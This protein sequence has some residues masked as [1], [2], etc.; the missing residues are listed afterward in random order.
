MELV[1]RTT[2]DRYMNKIVLRKW[3][4]WLKR[5]TRWPSPLSTHCM[6]NCTTCRISETYTID[7]QRERVMMVKHGNWVGEI[8]KITI[9][10]DG[11]IVTLSFHTCVPCIPLT[12]PSLHPS[13]DWIG[14]CI[15]IKLCCNSPGFYSR[16]WSPVIY[17][18]VLIESNLVS[19]EL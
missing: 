9:N 4:F 1:L 11:T 12:D 14:R 17:D 7:I 19:A 2:T 6:D 3:S 18:I 13:S 16:H 5:N 10:H 15:A 8:I